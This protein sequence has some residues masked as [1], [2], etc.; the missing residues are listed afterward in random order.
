MI[1]VK[2]LVF[3][4]KNEIE[5]RKI[6][7]PSFIYIKNDIDGEFLE[8]SFFKSSLKNLQDYAEF[9]LEIK[10]ILDLATDLKLWFY[11]NWYSSTYL[12]K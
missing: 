1:L 5:T 11:D 12:I 8:M 7:T 10:N 3:M 9:Y 6:L 2:N 4:E